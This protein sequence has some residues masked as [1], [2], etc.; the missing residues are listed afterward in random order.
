[1]PE[2]TGGMINPQTFLAQ[3]GSMGGLGGVS[4]L[5][6]LLQAPERKPII[7]K[8]GDVA[9]DP[10]TNAVLWQNPESDPA[11]PEIAKLIAARDKLPPGHPA[12][13]IFDDAIRKATTSAPGTTVNVNTAQDKTFENETALRKEFN[14]LP[15][16]VGY[17]AAIPAFKA[18]EDASKRLTPQSDINLIYGIAKLY[19]PT[20]VVR[21]GE[22]AT[23]ANS[24]AIPERIKSLAQ[25][26][27][28]NG[29][30][31][32]ETRAQ[33]MVEARQ[34]IGTLQGEYNGAKSTYEGIANK[35]QLDTGNVFAPVGQGIDPYQA[36]RPQGIPGMSA[37]DAELR[38]REEERRRQ[39]Q[40]GD[41]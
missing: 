14:T 16:V 10:V 11:P 31:T 27:Q 22:Y 24:Q 7:S 26:I 40:T 32:P 17:K 12:R 34:R 39:Q 4:A 28:G 1:M 36:P 5:N 25:Q 9:R 35:R 23:I 20:S 30:L 8:P 6:Q 37:I 15:E 29:K 2:R 21:E 33:L 41:W 13:Q 38:R 18:V 3:G 19:D